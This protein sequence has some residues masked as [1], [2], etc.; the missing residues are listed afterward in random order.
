MDS[1]N[2]LIGIEYEMRRD[3]HHVLY[4][5][6]SDALWYFILSGPEAAKDARN[7]NHIRKASSM[8]SAHHLKS[9]SPF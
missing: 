8:I 9:Q 7:A 6:S 4:E 5:A 2:P 3:G 1:S